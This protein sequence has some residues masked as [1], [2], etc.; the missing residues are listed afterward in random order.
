MGKFKVK[1]ALKETAEDV[2]VVIQASSCKEAERAANKMGIFVSDVLVVEERYVELQKQEPTP[3]LTYEQKPSTSMN[4]A[5]AA[6]PASRLIATALSISYA[7]I[8]TLVVLLVLMLLIPKFE[9][10]FN[11][12]DVT[13]PGLTLWLI[14]ASLWVAGTPKTGE[15]FLPGYILGSLFIICLFIPTIL[16]H[17]LFAKGKSVFITLLTICFILL[18]NILPLLIIGLAFFLPLVKLIESV[19]ETG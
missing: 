16:L 17:I 13:L 12:F 1:G 7:T 18:F 6:K 15:Q 19:S 2:E 3:R 4:V 9:D 14:D 5:V 8:F 10:I 11:D